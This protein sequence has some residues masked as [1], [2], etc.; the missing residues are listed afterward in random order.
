M[1][2]YIRYPE[3]GDRTAARDPKG[4]DALCARIISLFSAWLFD[5][6]DREIIAL[7]RRLLEI[8]ENAGNTGKT[9]KRQITP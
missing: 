6:S 4:H 5:A 9:G 7:Q 1:R 2:H 8:L 3:T